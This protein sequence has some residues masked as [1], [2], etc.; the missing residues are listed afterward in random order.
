MHRRAPWPGAESLARCFALAPEWRNWQTLASRPRRSNPSSGIYG[1]LS[2]TRWKVHRSPTWGL[3]FTS[4]PP[5]V[6]RIVRPLRDGRIDARRP[7]V[8]SWTK[9]RG[10]G[11]VT[12]CQPHDR[13]SAAFLNDL[14]TSRLTQCIKS[15]RTTLTIPRFTKPP[16]PIRVGRHVG[17]VALR[18]PSP[19]STCAGTKERAPNEHRSFW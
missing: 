18:L 15:R 10:S 11:N 19:G 1:S 16:Q 3:P 5:S 6:S 8:S 13:R 4:R 9:V 17:C 7:R 14:G 2:T 12:E